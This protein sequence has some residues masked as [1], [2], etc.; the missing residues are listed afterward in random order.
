MSQPLSEE[1]LREKV[2]DLVRSRLDSLNDT[3]AGMNGGVPTDD[4]LD[5]QSEITSDVFALI[6]QERQAWGE[7][8][9]RDLSK[10]F[11]NSPNKS[12]TGQ[13]IH[14]VIEARLAGS[15]PTEQTTYG[16]HVI[17]ADWERLENVYIWF[18]ALRSNQIRQRGLRGYVYKKPDGTFVAPFRGNLVDV[19]QDDKDEFRQQR[20]TSGRKTDAS[21]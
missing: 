3:S 21:S 17:P 6:L 10:T 18:Y 7:Q 5:I 11:A 8:E 2:S 19:I 12:Y 15:E 14:A 9:L 20:N 13:Q 4:I 1:S 16:E